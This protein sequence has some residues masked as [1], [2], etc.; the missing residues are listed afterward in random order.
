MLTLIKTKGTD[1]RKKLARLALIKERYKKLVLEPRREIE[2][3]L[4]KDLE[5]ET[6]SDF[7]STN[8]TQ[9]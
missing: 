5:E 4:E 3:E 2:F 1:G 7:R 6:L 8:F 9:V